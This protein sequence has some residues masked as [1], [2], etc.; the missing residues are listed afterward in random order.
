MTF[1]ADYIE[2]TPSNSIASVV[3]ANED[4]PDEPTYL[5]LT[6]ATD[7]ENSAYHFEVNDQS[8]SSYEGLASVKLSRKSLKLKLE[9]EK[10]KELDNTD[11]ATIKVTFDADDETYEAI[12]EALQQVFKD[13]DIFKLA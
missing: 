10:V 5:A 13:F 1:T 11:F 9:E 4:N 6:R 7:I 3:F 8:N 12:K 2:P